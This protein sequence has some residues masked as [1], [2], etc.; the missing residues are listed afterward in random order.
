MNK[1]DYQQ[2]IISALTERGLYDESLDLA[3]ETLAGLLETHERVEA[4]LVNEPY[5]TQYSREGDER[6]LAN[7]MSNL[8]VSTTEAIRKWMRD[9]GLVV[10]KP[11]GYVAQEK[12]D[13]PRQGDSLNCVLKALNADKPLEF[14]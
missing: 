13:R 5:I 12:D 8:Y 4:E 1:V 10:A 7:P 2:N 9:L 6:R 3:I 14:E 11:A